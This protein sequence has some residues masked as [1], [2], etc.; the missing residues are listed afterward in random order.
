MIN[1]FELFHLSLLPRKHAVLDFENYSGMSR[2]QW[3]RKVFSEKQS[4]THS[5]NVFH[6]APSSDQESALMF[7]KIGRQVF[8]DENKSPSE[9]FEDITHETWRASFIVLDPNHHDD[10]QKI[11]VQKINEVGSPSRLIANLVKR[12][13]EFYSGPYIIEVFQ[14]IEEQS[15]WEFVE[16]NE[17]KVTSVTL[18]L[19]PPNMF[20][21]DEEF[22][23]EMKEFS[24]NEAARKVKLS[25]ENEEGIN[26]NTDRMHRAVKYAS[27]G[28]GKIRAK[29]KGNKKY[30][31][32]DTVKRTY[33]EDIKEIGNK[34][35]MKLSSLANRVLGRE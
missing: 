8:R 21:S 9:G 4:F 16:Q 29:A 19:I 22:V 27:K 23:S 34:L 15:F 24:D 2:E 26:P 20:G 13:N 35:G 6:Y 12:I 1:Q 7:G 25:I 17:G 32:R 18:E 30:N 5:G 14:I 10:G 31:S 11:A 3:L 28:G 33:L